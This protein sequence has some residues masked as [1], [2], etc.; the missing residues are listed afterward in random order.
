MPWETSR[1]GTSIAEQT[2]GWTRPKIR[3]PHAADRWTWR[4]LAADLRRP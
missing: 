3:A 1:W 2:L 4:I